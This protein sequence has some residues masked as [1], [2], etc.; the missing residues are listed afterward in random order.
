[1]GTKRIGFFS[2]IVLF[3][4]PLPYTNKVEATEPAL[5]QTCLSAPGSEGCKACQIAGEYLTRDNNSLWVFDEKL[6]N[7]DSDVITTAVLC[8]KCENSYQEF[9]MEDSRDILIPLVC[10]EESTY[11]SDYYSEIAKKQDS[12]WNQPPLALTVDL[13]TLTLA[14][15]ST[16]SLLALLIDVGYSYAK[17]RKF[18]YTNRIKILVK[19]SLL[20]FILFG[21]MFFLFFVFSGSSV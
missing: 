6:S 16:F 18:Q 13:I 1:M 14:T 17:T 21:V 15:I 9:A 5:F 7:I 3:V 19:A 11:D 20:A 4:T 10:S 2:L 8:A 12:F